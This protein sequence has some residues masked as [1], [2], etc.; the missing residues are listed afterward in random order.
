MCQTRMV[1]V[2]SVDDLFNHVEFLSILN[3]T[4]YFVIG[5]SIRLA[6]KMY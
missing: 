5:A 2:H 6:S 1:Q 4:T 3:F